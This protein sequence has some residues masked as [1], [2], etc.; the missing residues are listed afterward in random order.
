MAPAEPQRGEARRHRGE[1]GCVGWALSHRVRCEGPSR[2]SRPSVPAPCWLLW[3]P[4]SPG[5][6]GEGTTSEEP[7][8]P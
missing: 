2:P 4:L 7:T 6:Y 3:S 1:Q 8:P 5:A